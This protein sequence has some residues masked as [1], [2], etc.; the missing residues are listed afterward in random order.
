MIGITKEGGI[1]KIEEK[2][3]LTGRKL[4]GVLVTDP[5]DLNAS[6]SN[7]P[8]HFYCKDPQQ[9]YKLTLYALHTNQTQLQQ[10]SEQP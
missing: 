5:K 4:V 1:V 8:N 2:T 6:Y 3:S 7:I 10:M 9:L